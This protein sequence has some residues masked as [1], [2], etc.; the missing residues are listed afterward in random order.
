MGGKV[1]K[2]PFLKAQHHRV[3]SYFFCWF[4]SLQEF[5]F[6]THVLEH[7]D[8]SEENLTGRHSTP[9]IH[10]LTCSSNCFY[11]VRGLFSREHLLPFLLSYHCHDTRSCA[12]ELFPFNHTWTLVLSDKASLS[13][14]LL[15]SCSL[16][17]FRSAACALKHLKHSHLFLR[18][19]TAL[20]V[21]SSESICMVSFP[22]E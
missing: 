15:M 10:P 1:R 3:L 22:F 13:I 16:L 9:A 18:G 2:C 8:V 19:P 6:S 17:P 4:E 11:I 5:P 12:M 21:R 7:H 14:L 20:A